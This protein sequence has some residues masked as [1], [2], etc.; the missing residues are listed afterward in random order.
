V[1][2]V[3][4]HSLSPVS[5]LWPGAASVALLICVASFLI[6][7]SGLICATLACL[8]LLGLVPSSTTRRILV[9]GATTRTVRFRK[10]CLLIIRARDSAVTLSA[11]I[12]IA[13]VFTTG[14]AQF[15]S[16][17]GDDR[18]LLIVL[19]GVGVLS[20]VGLTTLQSSPLRIRGLAP[21][22]AMLVAVSLTWSAVSGS[23]LVAAVP[24]GIGAGVMAAALRGAITSLAP[25]APTTSATIVAALVVG[26]G[27]VAGAIL[28]RV[29]SSSSI[30]A[31]IVGLGSLALAMIWI[32][33]VIELTAEVLFW[34][35][36]RVRSHGPGL[37]QFPLRGPVLVIANHAAW[38]DP[39][40][41]ARALPRPLTPLMLSTFYHLPVL[42]L[43]TR[44]IVHAIPVPATGFRRE[45]PEL[46]AAIAA[47]DRGES[48]LIFPEGW[49]RRKDEQP[50]RRFA[51]GVCR[52]LKERPGTPVVAC[53]V[54]G[55]WGSLTSWRDGPPLHGKP[56]DWRRN[57]AVGVSAPEVISTAVLAEEQA[58]RLYLMQACLEARR[59]IPGAA[60]PAMPVSAEVPA[61]EEAHRTLAA[62][63]GVS[64]AGTAPR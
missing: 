58:T 14:L 17:T 20:G 50:L 22:G 8:A 44:Y 32:R 59:H 7:G 4:A 49:L 19:A 53:W 62:Q 63:A 6:T 39:L 36:Y 60:A 46:T 23:W 5:R 48:V 26:L 64:T 15:G 21:L 37:E 52:I 57:I 42:S 47:L 33:P 43:L 25:E 3:P 45:T 27:T 18:M 54:E 41:V 2:S 30:L 10:G 55:G 40:W 38:L 9:R 12:G 11:L 61:A 16:A 24:F 13:I 56:L 29:S 31:V 1:A 34:P 51:Q 28:A 35:G